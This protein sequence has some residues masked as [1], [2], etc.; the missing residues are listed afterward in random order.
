MR[1]A[2]R[3]L[4][5]CR[6]PIDDILMTAVLHDQII[7]PDQRLRQ[8]RNLH[9]KPLCHAP[10][11]KV[12]LPV[13]EADSEHGEPRLQQR[14]V[15]LF[16]LVDEVFHGIDFRLEIRL[17]QLFCICDFQLRTAPCTLAQR[18]MEGTPEREAA[19]RM[20]RLYMLDILE[21]EFQRTSQV[22]MERRIRPVRFLAQL[23]QIHFTPP[24]R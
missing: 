21:L 13:L 9:G 2:R 11:R 19:A 3:P 8:P 4:R 5:A 1:L 6:F 10:D 15:I 14:P 22:A 12:I 20:L 7:L 24:F 23:I 18:R 16:R 17:E